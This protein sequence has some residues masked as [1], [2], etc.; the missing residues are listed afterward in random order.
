MIQLESQRDSAE[1]TQCITQG[2]RVGIDS[3]RKLLQ[4][5]PQNKNRMAKKLIRNL[6]TYADL[7]NSRNTCRDQ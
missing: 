7:S 5:K 6:P 2:F 3:S 4:T 1:L